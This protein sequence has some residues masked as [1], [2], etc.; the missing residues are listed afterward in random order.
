MDEIASNEL[1]SIL[2]FSCEAKR[3][4]RIMRNG[5]SQYV[6]SGF[7][8][9]FIM[10]LSKSEIPLKGSNNSP[11]LDGLRLSAKALIVKSRLF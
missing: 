8:G 7:N 1:F 4:A 11:K 3:I 6:I 9:V 2:K 5:S 10:P